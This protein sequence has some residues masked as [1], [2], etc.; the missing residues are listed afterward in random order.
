MAVD[1][2]N[3]TGAYVPTKA[4]DTAQPAEEKKS[5]GDPRLHPG[6]AQGSPASPG[7]DGLDRDTV[8]SGA[9]RPEQLDYGARIKP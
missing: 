1:P 3:D 6:G 8:P 2:T 9:V 7:M 4:P 5:Q